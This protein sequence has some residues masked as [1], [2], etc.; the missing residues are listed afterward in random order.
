MSAFS[1][2]FKVRFDLRD[3]RSGRALCRDEIDE[4]VNGNIGPCDGI[5]ER[6]GR[7][8]GTVVAGGR[9]ETNA[10]GGASEAES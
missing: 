8:R 4:P 1:D 2:Q 3:G 7:S 6:T 9:V 5:G 10:E